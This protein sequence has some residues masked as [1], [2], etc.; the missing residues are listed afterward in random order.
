MADKF[1]ARLKVSD[2]DF[3]T[4]KGN[5]KTYL[6]TQDQF[7]DMNFEGA[8]INILMDLLAYNTHYQAMYTNMV[9]NEMFLDSAIRRD[10]V[11]SLAKHLGYTPKSIVAPT[12]TVDVYNENAELTDYLEKGTIIKGTQGDSSF[13]FSVTESVGYTLDSEGSKYA[14]NVEIKEGKYETLSYVFDGTNDLKYVIPETADTSTITVRVQKSSADST[15]YTD[16]WTLATDLNTVG[17][18]DKAY[19]IQ[20]LD[21]GEYEIFFGDDIVGKK[22]DNG[23]IV[24]IQ[25]LSTSGTSANNVGSADKEG[26]RVF[27]L[28]GSTVKVL[29]AAAG[30][31]GREDI[32]SIKFYAPKTYQTQE[33]S[34]TARDYEALILR[35]YADIESVYVWGGQDNDPPE[36]G[37][38]FLSI[39]PKSSLTLDTTKKETIK[40]DILKN[41]NVVTV[42]PEIV[43]PDYLFLLIES[44]LIYDRSRTILDKQSVMSLVRDTVLDYI[45]NDLEK[46]DKDL[47][48]SKLTKL[49]DESSESLKGNDTK[50][51]IQRR[52][53]PALNV[54][55]NY[56][57]EFGNP[58]YHPHDGHMPILET[59]GFEYKDDD[60]NVFIGYLDDDGNGKVRMWKIGSFGEKIYVYDK[61]NSIGTI[62]YTTG[63]I[64]LNKFRPLSFLNN[65]DI[66]MNVPLKDKNV[67][68]NRSRILTM[69]SAD[70][71]SLILS[72]EEMNDRSKG[73]GTTSSY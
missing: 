60:D 52:F 72:I 70:P 10:S 30:G 39:K 11:V 17:K 36:Y 47:Y 41:T 51:K 68:A 8:G 12:A 3:D 7:K 29:S 9:A 73:I 45:D 37:K 21:N 55:S 4:I 5:L 6:S 56:T 31:A 25:Y 2:L 20:E 15:G 65:I 54:T 46:F 32:K 26:A 28:S 33:R 69:D 19:H 42:I 22:P 14:P 64:V 53:V 27:T 50:I 48:F 23:N 62:D 34:V 38:V 40:K 43:D 35:D 24:I 16:K 49:M 44:R 18:T 13:N 71:E 1:N 63:K 61:E 58:F 57:I 66:R 67:F 59:G